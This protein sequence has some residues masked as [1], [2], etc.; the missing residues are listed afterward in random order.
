LVNSQQSKP[1]K[2]TFYNGR[3]SKSGYLTTAAESNYKF[4]Q[5]LKVTNIKNNKSIIVEVNDRGY[6]EQAKVC[7]DL[8][9]KSFPANRVA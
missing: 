3:K 2:A 4:G 9:K 6:F 1:C 7:L 5:I 8:S